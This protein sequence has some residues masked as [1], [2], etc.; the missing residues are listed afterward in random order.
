MEE[1]TMNC[2]AHR[3]R[4][5]ARA[6]TLPLIAALLPMAAAAIEP[7]DNKCNE[8]HGLRG[9]PFVEATDRGIQAE[10]TGTLL[11][12]G[13]TVPTDG[14]NKNESPELRGKTAL[15]STLAFQFTT[16]GGTVSGTYSERH[17]TGKQDR[18]CKSHL[19]VSVD[20]GCISRLRFHNYVHP[21]DIVADFR[22]DLPRNPPP[23][24]IPS[25]FASRSS[26]GLTFEFHLATHVCAGQTSRWLLLNT[27]INALQ[28]VNGLELFAPNGQSS[29]LLPVHVPI[30]VN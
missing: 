7:D 28:I 5:V 4:Q 12:P 9:D 13:Q 11:L 24:L 1:H 29:A 15:Q 10:L 30:P 14:T 17:D 8:N 21:L 18:H 25:D 22:D 2:H 26:D 16:S 19:R 6:C 20:Q 23:G 27:S 3:A